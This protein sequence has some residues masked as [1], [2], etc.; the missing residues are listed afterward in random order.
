M[1]YVVGLGMQNPELKISF[2]SDIWL[3]RYQMSKSGKSTTLATTFFFLH[4]CQSPVANT[5]DCLA[6]SVFFSLFSLRASV[7]AKNRGG[8]ISNDRMVAP[9]HFGCKQ[10]LP[11][12]NHIRIP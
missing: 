8:A 10:R 9:S 11:K 1:G 5:V 2:Q 6:V 4:F 12:L 7:T 3:L